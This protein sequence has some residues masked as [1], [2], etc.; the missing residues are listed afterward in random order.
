VIES[1]TTYDGNGTWVGAGAIGSVSTDLYEGYSSQS[2]VKFR[3][4]GT[5]GTLTNSTF[6][7]VDLSMYKDRSNI[8]LDVNITEITNLTSFTLKW[9]TDASNYYTATVTTDYLGEAF[10]EEW[11]RLKFA[12]SSP[13]TV[14]T[15]TDSSIRYVQLTCAYAS[16]PGGVVMRVQNLFASENVPMTL[17]YYSS[18]M[19]YDVSGAVKTQHF[20]DATATTDYPLWSGQWD[21]VTE[22]FINSC[23][24]IV[25]WITGEY[26]DISVARQ[27]IADIVAP[28][29][30]RYP[31]QRRK[32][33]LFVTTDT[34]Y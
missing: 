2:S 27:K 21:A 5:S 23:L 18:N 13:T 11:V 10:K 26:N 28:L 31:S 29:K 30:E 1:A 34:N 33:A 32:P 22:A 17:K 12:W 16:N 4:T 24:E 15:P 19:V 7:P 9:G 8:Y 14:G 6:N 25:F 3:Y 20:N